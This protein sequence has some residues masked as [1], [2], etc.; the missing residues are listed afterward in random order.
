MSLFVINNLVLS[1]ILDL[2]F[3]EVITMYSWIGFEW[4]RVL[5]NL[6]FESNTIQYCVI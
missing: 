5:W 4:C 6:T 1:G 3:T 2:L